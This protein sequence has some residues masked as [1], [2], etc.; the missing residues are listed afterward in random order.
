MLYTS[1]YGNTGV[2]DHNGLFHIKQNKYYLGSSQKVSTSIESF[3]F[4]DVIT[5]AKAGG[6]GTAYATLEIPIKIS[7]DVSLSF[8]E[9]SY[10][11]DVC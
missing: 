2:E 5:C 7:G 6:E 4:G 1:E 3:A 10:K 9:A 8:G 11:V